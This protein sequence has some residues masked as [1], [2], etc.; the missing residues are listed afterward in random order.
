MD[1]LQKARRN[2]SLT[3][4]HGL[5][6]KRISDQYIVAYPRSGSTWL[7]TILGTLI[8]PENGFE[9]DVFNAL[10]PSV[11]LRCLGVI[12]SLPDP[13][14]MMSHTTYRRGL[15]RVVYEV[16]DGR[17]SVVSLYH[18]STTRAGRQ[19]SFPEW[20]DLYCKRQFGACWH[21]NVEGWLTK[22]R[23]QLGNNMLVVK[24]EEVKRAP[25]PQIQTIASFLGIRA[26]EQ[27]IGRAIEMAGVDKA[28]EREKRQFG[29]LDNP[30]ASF[31]RGGKTGQWQ[32][33]LNGAIY[34]KFL[35]LSG[36]ALKLAGYAQ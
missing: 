23:E 13:R 7:R 12:R 3:V 4:I 6:G 21:E 29:K 28:R 16:R 22:G 8:A 14:L 27:S 25:L 1:Y 34:Q 15:R 10:I 20:F 11:G 24:F 18:H 5:T 33:Y 35:D 31:Y 9:P 36:A 26:D 32:E 2:M 17:D 19:L 30:D